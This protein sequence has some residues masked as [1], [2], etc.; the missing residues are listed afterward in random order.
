MYTFHYH[1]NYMKRYNTNIKNN[2]L[3]LIII[4]NI[5]SENKLINIIYLLFSEVL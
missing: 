4:F 2:L 5:Q 3:K 1:K